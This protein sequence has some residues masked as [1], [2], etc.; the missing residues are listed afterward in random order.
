MRWKRHSTVHF[1]DDVKQIPHSSIRRSSSVF[2][3][4]SNS[5]CVNYFVTESRK[6]KNNNNSLASKVKIFERVNQGQEGKK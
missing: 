6:S 2:D 3:S 1:Q 4:L 5:L